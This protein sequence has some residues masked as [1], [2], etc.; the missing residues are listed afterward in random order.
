MS[1]LSFCNIPLVYNSEQGAP[2]ILSWPYCKGLLSAKACVLNSG[3]AWLSLLPMEHHCYYLFIIYRSTSL[4]LH[5]VPTLY[6]CSNVYL[7]LVTSYISLILSILKIISLIYL[8]GCFSVACVNL[9]TIE[10][11]EWLW[12]INDHAANL[13]FE[14]TMIIFQHFPSIIIQSTC[15]S[16]EI[17]CLQYHRASNHLDVFD[18]ILNVRKVS[19]TGN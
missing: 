2:L 12:K 9:V 15:A 11:S 14:E 8:Q 17:I 19:V 18:K 1:E 13:F 7:L 10:L 6:L 16:T 5:T 4:C 3:K